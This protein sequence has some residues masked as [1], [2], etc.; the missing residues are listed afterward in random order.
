MLV[1][2]SLFL[3]HSKGDS[4]MKVQGTFINDR[5]KLGKRLTSAHTHK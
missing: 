1:A 4:L 2:I 3:L 5:S